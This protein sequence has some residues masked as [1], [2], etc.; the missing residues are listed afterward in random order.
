VS[1]LALVPT[2]PPVL[3]VWGGSLPHGRGATPTHCHSPPSS[4]KVE[5]EY[6]ISLLSP[7]S[8]YVVCSG[9]ALA[10]RYSTQMWQT[11]TSWHHNPDTKQ[12]CLLVVVSSTEISSFWVQILYTAFSCIVLCSSYFPLASRNWMT[13]RQTLAVTAAK[14]SQ[15]TV[16]QCRYSF[17]LSTFYC[18]VC[19]YNLIYWPTVSFRINHAWNV[20]PVES[21]RKNVI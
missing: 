19:W 15:R 7:P 12:Y 8:T 13:Q 20:V 21:V 6:Q 9:T 3:W 2:Q 11:Q 5:N 17:V 18:C 4:A 16:Q 14:I 1:S 10:F